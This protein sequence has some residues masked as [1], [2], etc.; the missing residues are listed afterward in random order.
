MLDL[1]MEFKTRLNANLIAGEM[2]DKLIVDNDD[3]WNGDKTRANEKHELAKSRF[4]NH[5]GCS[6]NVNIQ[7]R[8]GISI[9]K[10]KIKGEKIF[11]GSENF[12]I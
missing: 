9:Y 1:F 6:E 4:R 3:G 5:S 7:M 8:C 10:R 11:K 2:V 12:F